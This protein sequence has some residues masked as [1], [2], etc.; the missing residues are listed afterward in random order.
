[1]KPAIGDRSRPLGELLVDA[2]AISED[3]LHRAL[4]AQRKSNAR[5]GEILVARGEATETDIAKA[6]AVQ[7]GIG[8]IDL[9][10]DD[11]NPSLVEAADVPLYLRYCALPWQ[12]LGKIIQ[13]V[14]ADPALAEQAIRD[15]SRQNG[16]AFVAVGQKSLIE[17]AIAARAGPSLGQLAASRVPSGES[18][19]SIDI[20][21]LGTVLA[22]IAVIGGLLLP[23]STIVTLFICLLL[24]LN[25]VTMLTR[26]AAIF[27][28]APAK[29]TEPHSDGTVI[30]AHHRKL[31]RISL[32]IPLFGEAAMI[33]SLVE[34]LK[35]IDYPPELIDAKLLLEERDARTRAAAEAADLPPWVGILVVPD[36]APRTKPRAMNAALDFCD[37]E[38]V[39]ILDAEDRPAPDQL[40]AVA[41]HLAA[42]PPEIA[43][44]QCQLSYFNITENWITRCFTIE[45]AI[46]FGVLLR[47]YQR[48][49]IPIPLGGTSVYFRRSAL[50]DLCGWDAH[51]VTEDADLGMRL[52]RRGMRCD[53][54]PTTTMEEANCRL[55]PWIRQRS[56]W[57][58]GYI[59]TW[60]SHMRSPKRLW[61]D[62]G[63]VGFLGL[64][65][66]F[67][68]GAITYLGIPVF[69][70]AILTAA[71][72]GDAIL[73]GHVPFW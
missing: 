65:V 67:I 30:L 56:R 18:V 25:L 60:L 16:M 32:L 53:V 46:W 71:V 5:I 14:V 6:L 72:T 41:Q 26:L 54:I 28:S 23:V 34:G 24:T 11:G 59:M 57:L 9:R 47:G 4:R 29:A 3:A 8:F 7:W 66:L 73:L 1:E 69:W 13:Y 33:D 68:G 50:V 37:G 61:S 43:C 58:K 36:G 64:N 42:A 63:P 38:I 45:Y 40:S 20:G 10:Q 49:G 17:Q 35:Q 15:L 39:G 12:R 52:A 21:R 2:G 19:R 70:L 22:S 44:V 55:V 31:P 51:N 27:L 48:L 62:L